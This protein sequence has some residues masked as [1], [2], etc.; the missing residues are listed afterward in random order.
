MMR[1]CDGLIL[2]IED[3]LVDPRLKKLRSQGTATLDA[4]VLA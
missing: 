3:V 2:S 1:Q 4:L